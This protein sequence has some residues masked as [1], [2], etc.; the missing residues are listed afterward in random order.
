MFIPVDSVWL[1]EGYEAFLYKG[2]SCMFIKLDVLLKIMC[3]PFEEM[4]VTS[5]VLSC[6]KKKKGRGV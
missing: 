4:T 1:C 3:Q 6:G 5:S 2:Y